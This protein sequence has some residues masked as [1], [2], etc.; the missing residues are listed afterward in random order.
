MSFADHYFHKHIT[1]LPIIEEPPEG[2][3]SFIV[4]IPVYLESKII[5]TLESLRDSNIPEN[6]IEVLIVVNYSAADSKEN[7]IFNQSTYYELVEWCSQNSTRNLKFF[8]LLASDLPSKHAGAG[9]ARKI[10]MDQALWRFNQLKKANGL[11]L[12]LDADTLVDRDYFRAI[13]NAM[14]PKYN[15]DDGGCIIYFEH[16]IQG[17]EFNDE[18]YKAIIQYELHLRYYKYALKF[19][20]F[21]FYQ[22]TIGSCF[23]IR[24][25]YYAQQGGM[26]RRKGGE[27][28]Y[29]LH[30]LFP[31]KPFVFITETCVHPSPRPS[32]RVPFGTGPAIAKLIEGKEKEYYTYSPQS[33]YDLK[34]FLNTIPELYRADQ[35]IIKDVLTKLRVSISDFLIKNV[36][37]ENT[38]DINKNSASLPS[39]IKRFYSWFDGFMVVRYLNYSH[40][41]YF[42]KIPAVM[43]VNIFLEKICSQSF[44]K[45]TIEL[46]QIFKD[47]ELGRNIIPQL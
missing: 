23:G 44:D 10:G 12:S 33:F 17:D 8:P 15:S 30:K 46:L 4:V 41:K 31:H 47:H 28:F 27:D 11:I 5:D 34:I 7:K 22:Y 26:N 6:A 38:T 19:A 40:Q 35:I 25:E 16:P 42:S 2:L 21:P 32:P 13:E 29:F 39:F 36:F 45:E 43:A 3:L 24:A 1:F 18:V 9:F 14:F 20:G 37:E